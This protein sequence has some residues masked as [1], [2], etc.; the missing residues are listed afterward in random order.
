MR[1]FVSRVLFL[2]FCAGPLVSQEPEYKPNHTIPDGRQIM[3]VYLGAQTCGPCLFPEVKNAVVRMKPLVAEQARKAGAA[4]AAIGGSSDW[5]PSVA[6]NFLASVGPFDQIVLGGNFT[7]MAF[8]HFVW[9][10]PKGTAGM[11]QILILERTVT[12]DGRITFSEPRVLRRLLGHAEIVAWVAQGAPI[13]PE[14]SP[15][16]P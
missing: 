5:D 6:A 4:F 11:P 1:Y 12:S 10:V 16:R 15:P 7:N 3:A 2:S 8:E 14:T 13:T 9:R